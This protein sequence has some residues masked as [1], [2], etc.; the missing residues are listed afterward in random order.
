MK[1]STPDQT[2]SET[3]MPGR[4]ALA[5]ISQ[6]LE[7]APALATKDLLALL[8]TSENGLN[9]EE[10][11]CRLTQFGPNEV[12]RE[13]H[14][15]WLHRF[16]TAGRNPLVILLMVLAGLSFATGDFRAGTVMLL[17]VVLGLS[18]RFV[19]ETKA[20]NAAAKLKAMISVTAAVVR[21]EKAR[22]IPLRE[23]VPGD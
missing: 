18:L 21:E 11:A 15:T 13:K 16:Y 9:E 14:Y 7:Q 3:V 8:A 2:A 20:D 17:M 23:L 19:Q 4:P 22:E 1:S 5:N 12:A 10:A 6:A